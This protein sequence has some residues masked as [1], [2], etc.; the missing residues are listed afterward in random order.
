VPAFHRPWHSQHPSVIDNERLIETLHVQQDIF[1]NGGEAFEPKNTPWFTHWLI[2]FSVRQTT[3]TA[4]EICI[5]YK[6]KHQDVVPDAI[7]MEESHVH[8]LD[9][10]LCQGE[11][12]YAYEWERDEGCEDAT[13]DLLNVW[14]SDACNPW[15]EESEEEKQQRERR[16]LL[17]AAPEYGGP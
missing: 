9:T 15:G 13:R 2:A 1:P 3:L 14:L 12:E 4:E 11:H 5:L 16:K 17:D 6:Y 7:R 8:A 10:M